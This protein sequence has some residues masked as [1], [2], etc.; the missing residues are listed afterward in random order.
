MTKGE[1]RV[2]ISFNPSKNETV[3]KIKRAVADL[4]D[5]CDQISK[6]EGSSVMLDAEVERLVYM[7]QNGFED[8]AMW[9]VK[10]ATRRD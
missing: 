6:S 8:A 9:A 2:G 4:I 7:A 5:V 10:A 1:I 3:D